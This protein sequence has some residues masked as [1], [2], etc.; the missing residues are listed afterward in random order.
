MLLILSFGC[1]CRRFVGI[2]PRH[3][4]AFERAHGPSHG[5][6]ASMQV[7]LL[8]GVRKELNCLLKSCISAPCKPQRAY[9]LELS[10]AHESGRSAV[11]RPRIAELSG[12]AVVG[13]RLYQ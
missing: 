10:K 5:M 6:C 1:S 12:F 8:F 11:K 7:F 13:T 3:S 4:V 2:L 9:L